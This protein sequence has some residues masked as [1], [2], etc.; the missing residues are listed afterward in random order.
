MLAWTDCS[1][2]PRARQATLRSK[3]SEVWKC[4]SAH[5]PGELRPLGYQNG[6]K[7]FTTMSVPGVDFSRR[8]RIFWYSGESYHAWNAVIDG[9]SRMTVRGLSID[10]STTSGS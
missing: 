3:S 1:W 8:G 10:P 7:P 9:N 4:S 6:L 2:L 5:S